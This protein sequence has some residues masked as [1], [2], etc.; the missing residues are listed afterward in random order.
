MINVGIPT[1]VKKYNE[2]VND[3]MLRVLD[4]EIGNGQQ[5]ENGSSENIN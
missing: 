2:R 4:I 3:L 5:Q 1:D